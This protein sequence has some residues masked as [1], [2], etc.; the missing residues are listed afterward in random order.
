M[1][2]F[3]IFVL[4]VRYFIAFALVIRDAHWRHLNDRTRPGYP[5]D[6]RHRTR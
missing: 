2:A 4:T 6:H 3:L 5:A 1:T